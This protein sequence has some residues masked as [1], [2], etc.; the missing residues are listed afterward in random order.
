MT[1]SLVVLLAAILQDEPPKPTLPPVS[2]VT[3]ELTDIPATQALEEFEAAA[4]FN[5]AYQPMSRSEE[6][7]DNRPMSISMKD[8]PFVEAIS[9]FCRAHGELSFRIGEGGMS[10]VNGADL[11]P[12]CASDLFGFAVIRMEEYLSTD[13]SDVRR[14]LSMSL[15]IWGQPDLRVFKLNDVTIDE[16]VDDAGTDLRIEGV[17]HRLDG[18]HMAELSLGLPSRNAATVATLRGSVELEVPGDVLEV[19]LTDLT[20]ESF[21]PI[22]AGDYVVSGKRSDTDDGPTWEVV[23]KA[24]EKGRAVLGLTEARVVRADGKRPEPGQ[25]A[26]SYGNEAWFWDV[27][28]GDVKALTFKIVTSKARLRVPFEFKDVKLPR[29]K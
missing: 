17:K 3:L 1:A 15:S 19:S 12:V 21:G 16:A 27:A 10:V 6:G 29:T 5:V 25:R 24:E 18:L 28:D 14:S 4:G 7:M 9:K 20:A 13:F 23:V 22:K 26:R 2:R 11:S 8:T